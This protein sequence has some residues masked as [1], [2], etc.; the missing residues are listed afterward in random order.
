[1]AARLLA[2]GYSVHGEAQSRERAEHL[3]EQGLQWR[4]TPRE[5]SESV[6]V[7]FTSLPDDRVLDEVA[8]G[9]GGILAGLGAG[10]T[11]EFSSACPS[12]CERDHC[13]AA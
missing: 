7:V 4:G 1:M 13:A 8:S 2:A 10:W 9:P 3:I 5:L 12:R 6:D 11:T